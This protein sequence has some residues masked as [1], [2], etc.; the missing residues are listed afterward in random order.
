[1]RARK[2]WRKK[3]KF[4]LKNRIIINIDEIFI[5]IEIMKKVIQKKKKK[6]NINKSW[7][8]LRKIQEFI[9]ILK[10]KDKDSNFLKYENIKIK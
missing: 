7:D 8:K 2:K 10:N 1:M 4:I 9:I 3:K 6:I 5:I